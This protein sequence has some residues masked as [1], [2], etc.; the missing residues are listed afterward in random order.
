[1]V[2]GVVVS[3]EEEEVVDQALHSEVLFGDVGHN[4]SEDLWV[5]FALGDLELVAD[6]G[7]WCTE[8]V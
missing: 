6:H 5:V 8:F 2:V 7:D 1:M 3:C 4:S